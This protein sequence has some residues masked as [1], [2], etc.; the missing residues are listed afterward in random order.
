MT[1]QHSLPQ[2][3]DTAENKSGGILVVLPC[4][5]A[6]ECGTRRGT[7]FDEA[8]GYGPVIDRFASWFALWGIE[9]SRTRLG[10][11]AFERSFS[12]LE[13]PAAPVKGTGPQRV[14]EI[15]KDIETLRAALDERQPRL[16]IFLSAYGWQAMNLESSVKALEPL[17]GKPKD[18]GRRITAERLG[19]WEQQWK[20]LS[21]LAL[22]LPS[23]NTTDT[24]ILTLSKSVQNAIAKM[25]LLP[26]KTKDPLM[27]AALEC[28][29]L[30][31]EATLKKLRLDLHIT[32][33]RAKA[34]FDALSADNTTQDALGNTVIL[35]AAKIRKQRS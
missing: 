10:A 28:L 19:A 26:L 12:L 16:V 35:P 7:L 24:Y 34:L 17:I 33:K 32:E 4:G 25:G 2:T 1:A 27:S 9:V 29:V 22:P 20:K 21:V 8:V 11:G 5:T 31:R 15:A 13:W 6:A 18:A 14:P 23:K 3:I 30:D